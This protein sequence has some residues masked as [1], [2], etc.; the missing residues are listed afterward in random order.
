M[1]KS[2]IPSVSGH[3]GVQI[4]MLMG[5]RHHHCGGNSCTDPSRKKTGRTDCDIHWDNDSRSG[6]LGITAFGGNAETKAKRPVF[7]K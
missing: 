3:R 4:V 6:M 1:V 5:F 2:G 7:R